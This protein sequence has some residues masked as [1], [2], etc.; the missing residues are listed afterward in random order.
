MLSKMVFG[1]KITSISVGRVTGA[2][3]RRCSRKLLWLKTLQTLKENICAPL[4]AASIVI[5]RTLINIPAG[6][7]IS[8]FNHSWQY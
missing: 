7:D 4:M 6:Q 1:K 8:N 3:V 2:A 5:S